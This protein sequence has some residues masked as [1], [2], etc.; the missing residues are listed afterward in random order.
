MC[1]ATVGATLPPFTR[2]VPVDQTDPQQLSLALAGEVAAATG[3]HHQDPQRRGHRPVPRPGQDHRA[4]PGRS[5]HFQIIY[6][7]A[8]YL[9]T[10]RTID[11]NAGT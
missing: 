1:R 3:Q 2:V 10:Y 9:R 7:T 8:S 5:G 6:L 11:G 4:D